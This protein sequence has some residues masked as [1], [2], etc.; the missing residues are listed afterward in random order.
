MNLL[1][2]N[3][4]VLELQSMASGI[5][6]QRYGIERVFT[7]NS[8]DQGR[9]VLKSEEIDL[10][11]C[12]IEMP[13]E[14]GLSLIRWIREQGYDIDCILLTCHE[15]FA[16]AKEAISLNCREY[17]VLPAAYEDIG[18]TVAR[19]ARQRQERFNAN[20]LQEYGKNWIRQ[21]QS[22][23]QAQSKVQ[24]QNKKPSRQETVEKC[25]AYIQAH[26][27]DEDLNVNEIGAHFYMNPVYLSRIFKQEKGVSINQW[28][29]SQR[30]EL[31]KELL[32]DPSLTAVSVANHCGYY[33]YPY[34][35]TVFKKYYGYTPSQSPEQGDPEK[36]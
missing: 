22:M 24:E 34:F 14:D 33:N 28:I 18:E 8:A 26:L 20:R 6:W 36:K 5:P 27:S 2:I 11:L 4:A 12:D 17:I 21:Q 1:M 15:D 30:M 10:V 23:I 3:D 35:S 16:Y 13:G 29:I 31:A 32:K 25:V 19:I 9:S 7:A